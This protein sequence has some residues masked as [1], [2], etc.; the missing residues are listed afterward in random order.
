VEGEARQ[1]FHQEIG[2]YQVIGQLWNS[3]IILQSQQ[4]LYYVDQHALAE[5][6]AYE[7][8]KKAEDL[9]AEI[10]LQP[11]KFEITQ[12]ANIPEKMEQLNQL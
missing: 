3:Y 9:S 12:V 7:E 4:A 8:M 11:L 5:R 6:I 10:L 1:F 2:E